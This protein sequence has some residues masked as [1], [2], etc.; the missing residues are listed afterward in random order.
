VETEVRLWFDWERDGLGFVFL[1]MG[2]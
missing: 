2:V 1:A